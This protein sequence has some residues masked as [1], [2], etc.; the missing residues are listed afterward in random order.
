MVN[1][2]VCLLGDGNVG[3]TTL[4][5]VFAGKPVELNYTAT[6]G[7]GF[8]LIMHNFKAKSGSIP[9]RFMVYDLAGQPRYNSIR[10]QYMVGSNAALLV[11]DVTN[12]TSFDNIIKWL[13]QFKDVVSTE[14]PMVLIANKV[15]LR[16]KFQ[17]SAIT[18]EEGMGLLKH[19]KDKYSL[20]E[21]NY[22]HYIETSAINNSNVNESFDLISKNVY[23]KYMQ[24]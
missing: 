14:I 3:K 4:K 6:I 22:I 12:R 17:N 2:K 24:D 5:Q 8:S 11:Y 21:H 13:E 7:A 1:I 18:T 16:D 19:I 10:K 23:D 15:D 9:I 20:R